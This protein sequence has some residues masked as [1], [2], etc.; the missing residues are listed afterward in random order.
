MPYSLALALTAVAVTYTILCV[1]LRQTEH[2]EES[3]ATENSISFVTPA[4][5]MMIHK[6]KFHVRMRLVRERPSCQAPQP[7]RAP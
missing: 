1:L 4:L 6:S 3:P 5:K 2:E 7:S